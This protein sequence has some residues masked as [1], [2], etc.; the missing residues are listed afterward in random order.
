VIAAE[1]VSRASKKAS[2]KRREGARPPKAS[3]VVAAIEASSME[4]DE[5][6]R[7]LWANLLAQEL[8][9]ST[10]HPE[11]ARILER[12]TASDAQV[13]A[14][15]ASEGKRTISRAKINVFAKS[16]VHV[17]LLQVQE[18]T[19][20]VT[21]HLADLNLIEKVDGLWNLTATR[22]AFIEAV[23]DPSLEQQE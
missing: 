13:L 3:L 2:A 12:L 21:E 18:R 16:L 22:H 5:T 14:K 6:L 1:V 8:I 19:S 10:V 20:F 9:D 7:E 17:G 23:S 4:T 11:F 15:I